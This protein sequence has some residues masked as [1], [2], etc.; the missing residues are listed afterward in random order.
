MFDVVV[1][2][3]SVE[4]MDP[5]WVDDGS[6]TCPCLDLTSIGPHLSQQC[7]AQADDPVQAIVF[8]EDHAIDRSAAEGEASR[9]GFSVVL[10]SIFSYQ[11]QIQLPATRQAPKRHHVRQCFWC[12]CQIQPS[13]G[14][15]IYNNS[16]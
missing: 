14:C 16:A 10:A 5:D 2:A 1:G 7:L 6:R 13:Q 11:R 12:P 15:C 8:S 9:L 3:D 4:G